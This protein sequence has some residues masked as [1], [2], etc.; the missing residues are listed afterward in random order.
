MGHLLDDMLANLKV[1]GDGGVEAFLDPNK[2]EYGFGWEEAC[3]AE[4]ALA[5]MI[6]RLEPDDL[7]EDVL[8]HVAPMDWV[9]PM[10]NRITDEW[11]A[12]QAQGVE[13]EDRT[14]LVQAWRLSLGSLLVGCRTRLVPPEELLSVGLYTPWWPTN[15][16]AVALTEHLAAV[17]C[18]VEGS[19]PLP[20]FLGCLDR[21]RLYR[22]M[23]LLARH[24]FDV[25]GQDSVHPGRTWERDRSH[26][27]AAFRNFTG[28]SSLRPAGVGAGF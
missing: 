20:I 4:V 22:S 14:A 16:Y 12:A 25:R 8:A 19:G 2:Y 21:R 10:P 15:W 3:A 6:F 9:L 27:G 11:L 7:G 13:P 28:F 23:A 18:D 1:V 26:R 5:R 17:A 24:C